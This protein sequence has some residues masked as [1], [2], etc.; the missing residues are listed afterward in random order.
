MNV[1]DK[2]LAV[3]TVLCFTA[4]IGVVSIQ[5]FSRFFPFSF[6]WTEEVTRF[7]FIYAVSFA[8]PLAMRNKEFMRL[9]F[10]ITALP[11]KFRIFLESAIYLGVVLFCFI[12]AYQGYQFALIGQGQTSATTKIDMSFIHASIGISMLFTGIYT[13]INLFELYSNKSEQKELSIAEQ[14]ER[15]KTI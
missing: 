1:L 14:A 4:I 13:I 12:A 11:K 6:I 2:T 8:A 7:L 3:L 9:D 15:S 5:I 10:L